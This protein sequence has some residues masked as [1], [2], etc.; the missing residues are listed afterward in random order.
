MSEINLSKG[1]ENGYHLLDGQLYKTSN[2]YVACE[3]EE[4]VEYFKDKCPILL[5]TEDAVYSLTNDKT[6]VVNTRCYN[7][8][9]LLSEL[10]V[11]NILI[12][13]ERTLVN[14]WSR[15]VNIEFNTDREEF[16]KEYEDGYRI[17]HGMLL[18]PSDESIVC[19]IEETIEFF[20]NTGLIKF[21]TNDGNGTCYLLN[22]N[23]RVINT[24]GCVFSLSDI[25]IVIKNIYVW[26]DQYLSWCPVWKKESQ[27][28]KINLSG[29]FEVRFE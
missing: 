25:I 23:N 13:Y 19:S 16:T 12:K 20:K 24:H 17:I 7:D 4:V 8:L 15:E 18:K 6:H 28:N 29:K 2:K 10:Y 22:Y 5:E 26:N 21:E 1:Y 3:K 14:V 9:R 11:K 27:S